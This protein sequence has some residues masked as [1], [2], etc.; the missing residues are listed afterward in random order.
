MKKEKD[1][2]LENQRL[3]KLKWKEKNDAQMLENEEQIKKNKIEVNKLI[4]INNTEIKNQNLNNDFQNNMIANSSVDQESLP[5]KNF[6]DTE[7]SCQFCGL[8][9]PNFT[10]SHFKECQMLSPCFKCGKIIEISKS[11]LFE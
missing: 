3:E 9:D 6:D 11:S 5:E 8:N 7:H 4:S 10:S 2:E 1:S